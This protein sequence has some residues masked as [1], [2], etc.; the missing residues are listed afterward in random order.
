LDAIGSQQIAR[1]HPSPMM[2]RLSLE[3]KA[4]IAA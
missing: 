2:R 4:L 1:H 3:V